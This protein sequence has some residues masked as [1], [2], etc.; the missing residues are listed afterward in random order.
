MQYNWIL[1]E[2]TIFRDWKKFKVIHETFLLRIV[3]L[4]IFCYIQEI[5]NFQVTLVLEVAD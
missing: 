2:N 5:L 3:S 4:F 1:I